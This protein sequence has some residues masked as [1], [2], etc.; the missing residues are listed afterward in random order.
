MTNEEIVE[1]IQE[2]ADPDT[3]MVMLWEQNK[4]YIIFVIQRTFGIKFEKEDADCQDLMQEGFIALMRAAHKYSFDKEASFSTFAYK[5]IQGSLIRYNENCCCTVRLPSHLKQKIVKY[6]K[7]IREYTAKYGDRPSDELIMSSLDLSERSYNHLLKTVH[8]MNIKSFDEAITP[9]EDSETLM[10]FIDAGIDLADLVCRPVWLE[11][12][13][14]TLDAALRI[15]PCKIQ[16]A[17]RAKYYDYMSYDNISAVLGYANG[18]CVRNLIDQ[19]FRK[20]RHSKCAKDL[21]LF[22]Y[23]GFQPPEDKDIPPYDEDIGIGWDD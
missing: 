15:L 13:H 12:L 19:S 23:E 11:E 2:G 6:N 3:Y 9:E 21:I 10:A 8:Q 16:E 20:I 7:F 4:A 14:K 22:M 5:Y 17:I 18:H 1:K